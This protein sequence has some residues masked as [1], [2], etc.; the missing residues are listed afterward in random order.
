MRNALSK[1]TAWVLTFMMLFT[2]LPVNII[3][4]GVQPQGI[5]EE[6]SVDVPAPQQNEE[7]VSPASAPSEQESIKEQTPVEPQS[8]IPDDAFYRTYVFM[9]E[10]QEVAR[11]IVKNGDT[12]LQPAAP[13]KEGYRF[14]GWYAGESRFTG[15]GVVTGITATETVTL[16]AA[17]TDV[18]YVFFKNTNGAVVATRSGRN[19]ET[20]STSGVSFPVAG[21][22]AITGWLL[23]GTTVDSV[24]LDGADVTLT[25]QVSKGFWITFDSKGGSYVAPAFYAQGQTAAAPAAPARPG[26][27]FNGW[28]TEAGAAAD[29]AAIAENTT[30]VAGWKAGNASYTVIHFLENADDNGYSSKDIETR[31]G[32]TGSQTAAA[33]KS[34][35]GFTAQT[36]TQATIAGDGSTIVKVYYTRNVYEVKFYNR[37][38]NRWV[39]NTSLRITAKHG[40]NISDKWPTYNGSSTWSTTGSYSYGGGLSGPYQVNIQTMP[41]GGASFYGPKTGSGSETAY[42]YVEVLPGESGGQT[43]N[44]VSYKL[45]HKDVSPG[46]GYTVTDEDKYPITG[47]T[48]KEGTRNGDR[49]NNAK[50]YYTRNSYQIKFINGGSV[51][52]TESRKFQQSIADAEYTPAAPAGKEGYIFAGWYDN[53]QGE[54]EQFAFAGKTMPAQNI[55]LY[56]KWVAPVHTVTFYQE[57]KVT[58]VKAVVGIPHG[59]A[60]ENGDIPAYTPAEGYAF[61]GWVME[62]GSPFNPSMLITRDYHIYARVGS[63]NAYT[64]T[65][66]ANGGTGD[67]P[68]DDG[69]YAEGAAARVLSGAGLTGPADKPQFLG[70]A[71]SA[72]AAAPDYYPGSQLILGR[73]N[74]TLYAVWGVKE[75][76]V[77]LTYHSNFGTD[78]TY[79]V[80]ALA[81]NGRVEVL[82]YDTTGLPARQGYN[83]L[84]WSTSASGSVSFAPGSSLRVNA[85]GSNDLYAVWEPASDTPYRVETYYQQLDG[86]YLD[87]PHHAEIRKGTTGTTVS[88]TENDKL[89]KSTAYVFDEG[90]AGNVLSGVVAAD[91]SLK[92]KLYFKLNTAP[93][94]IHHYLKGT[95]VQVAADQTGWLVI[96]STL[97]ANAASDLYAEYAAATVYV[98]DPGRRI[99]ITAGNNEII[100]YYTLP[101]T[102]TAGSA[103]KVYDGAPLTQPAFTAEGLVNGDTAEKISLSMTAEST[104]TNVGSVSNVIDRTTVQYDGGA[105][106]AYYTLTLQ[107]G[108]LTVTQA[109][110]AVVEVRGG[111]DTVVYN[112]SEQSVE[113]WEIESNPADAIVTLKEGKRARAAGTDVNT[114][115]MGLTAEDF[116]A[117]SPNY[118]TVTVRYTDGWLKI[119]PITDEVTVTITGN[120]DTVVYN[121]TEQS[122][123]GYTTDVGEKT[124][125]VT[126]NQSGKDTAKGTNAG[127]YMMGLTVADFTVT[128][129]NYSNIRVVVVD[130][131]LEITP[132]TDEVEVKVYGNT[133]TVV[134]NGTEQKVEG[135]TVDATLDPTITVSLAE[136][137]KAEAKGT[138]VNKYMMG[139]TAADFVAASANYTNLKVTVADGWLEITPI[140]DEVEVKVYGNTSTVVYNGTEQKVEGYTV[141][142]TLD[143]TITVSLAEGSKAEAKGTDVNKYMMGLTAADFVA[144]SANYTNLKITVVDGWLEITPVTGEITVTIT[145]NTDTVVYNGT[146]QSV[147]GYTTDVGEKAIDVTLNQS[148]KDTA[149]GTNVGKY[150]MGLTVADFTVTSGNYS[151]IRVVVVDGWLEITPASIEQYATLTPQN[152]SKYYDGTPLAAGTATAADSNGGEL[153]VEYSVDGE[154][155]VTDPASITALNVSDSKTLQVRA[156]GSNY[157]GYLTGTQKVTINRR[158]VTL[159]SATAEKVYDGTPLTDGT[160]TVSEMGFVQGE[161]ADYSVTGSQLHKGFSTNA[162]TYT[163]HENTLEENYLIKTVSGTLTVT[164]RPLTI[165]AGS[166]SKQYDGTPLTRNSY[167]SEGLAAGDAIQTVTVTG[168][169]TYTGSVPNVPSDAVIHNGAGEDVTGDY[170]ITYNNGTLTITVNEKILKVEANSNSWKYDGEKHR[171]GGYTVIYDGVS[172]TV[173]AGDSLTLPTGDKVTVT[174]TAVVKNVSDTA[175]GNN[176]IVKLDLQHAD[177]YKIKEEKDGT[178]TITARELTL[179][180]GSDEKEYDGTPLTSKVVDITGDGFVKGEGAQ[181][182]VTGSQTEAGESDNTFTYTLNRN[183][184]AENYEITPVLG[185]LT[186]T[187]RGAGEKKVKIIANSYT[188]EYDGR[189]HGANGYTT[190]YLAPGHKVK[191][192]ILAGGRTD[193]GEYPGEFVPYDAAIVDANGNDVTHNYVITY[194]AG[195]LTITKRGLDPK[196][197]VIVRADNSEVEYDGQPHGY[198]GHNAS[199]LAEGHSVQSVESSF[200]AT[201]AGYYEAM[202]DVSDAVIVDA[203]GND[204][205]RNYA[206]TYIF[207]NLRITKRGAGER[208][209]LIIARDNTVEYDGQPHGQNGFDTDYLAPGHRVADVTIDGEKINAGRY[210]ALLYPYDAVIVDAEGNDVTHNYKLTYVKGTLEITPYAGEV[211]VTITGNHDRVHYDGAEHTVSGYTVDIDTALYTEADFRFKGTASVTK[212]YPGTYAMGLQEKDFVNLNE[213]LTNVKF[214]VTDG[215]LD[216]YTKKFMVAWM[217]DTN[218]MVNGSQPSEAFTAMTDYIHRKDVSLVLHT[219]NMVENAADA[220]QW[221]VFNDAMQKLYDDA[222]KDV[223]MVAGEKEA[224]AGSLFLQQPVREGFDEKDLFEGGKGFVYRFRIG[225]KR[226]ILV[227]LGEDA[228]TEEGLKWAK[229]RFDSDKKA[230]GILMVHTYLLA[231]MTQKQKIADS[232]LKLEENVVKPCSNVRLVLSS[233][234]GYASHHYFYYGMR[235]TTAINVDIEA[236]AKEGYFTMLTFDK[237]FHY[238][239]VNSLSPY[240]NDYIYNDEKAEL[241]RYHLGELY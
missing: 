175:A 152:V 205:T 218:Q 189:F 162:F 42:Y 38:S 16:T 82:S 24:T 227:G 40:A 129:R 198:V 109:E 43:Y 89:P 184:L 196:N 159:T 213:N 79:T 135:Y 226:M 215:Y 222:G 174:I 83:F 219:G 33:A 67:V 114:Y 220:G 57:D 229:E 113:G 61:L 194:V 65:Y 111:T 131:W 233:N 17:F 234:A 146:E 157:A 214:V 197:P 187:R 9:A 116:T 201:E 21:D 59:T 46:T 235:K 75:N 124:I 10:E 128:S 69:R 12:L 85:G 105:L 200:T 188:V 36:I 138:D 181:F 98:Y 90:Y 58:V 11:Q 66:D 122:V 97:T 23:N 28:F 147:T 212:V 5:V 18:F 182:D 164:A 240:R 7:E 68:V 30:L 180:S 160:V 204:V 4:E 173:A 241:E 41:L 48:Y 108:T 118:K 202:I 91:G 191:K 126:L 156:S 53:E 47:F 1:V 49:Y 60:M 148:G 80:E 88:V 110:E 137:S 207:G 19:G 120:T 179:T 22:E 2:A 239:A 27:V 73:E 221:K 211:V 223:L 199:N 153:L 117:V 192:L 103:E 208:K 161:G 183:T 54:G 63:L 84:G 56:A 224:A 144:A 171:D 130:G 133:N 206:I 203:K 29:F 115:Y 155:W 72:E 32:A 45:H 92:L 169:I 20:I 64:V 134:Y 96:G 71:L 217:Y 78:A 50:F 106:P 127:K 151:N 39:E 99:T 15:F 62:D 81:V 44:G 139:L 210:A 238:V 52:K 37:Q 101:L 185:S 193:A 236:A 13:A 8:V 95:T 70:W 31:T 172:Y 119:T 107:P 136:G 121:G 142:A 186:V 168:T 87:D 104:I 74:V 76:T 154:T 35:T 125:D 102:L 145:G 51:D 195:D 34:Y 141:D 149:K 55:T 178:L 94:T 158:P 177:Q 77:S 163:L 167:T 231:D 100:V 165:T 86:S 228:M 6:R 176:A 166:A 93:Y 25:A 170:E 123:T 140:T 143:P 230:V 150:M 14:D 132:I 209:V 216:I 26:Y 232:A 237:D 3:A 225:D 190:E 112:G